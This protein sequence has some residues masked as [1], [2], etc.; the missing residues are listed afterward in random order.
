MILEPLREV[1][2]LKGHVYWAV[3]ILRKCK[4]E[5]MGEDVI[6][7]IE[8]LALLV[9][10]FSNFTL[11]TF[12][13][14]CVKGFGYLLQCYIWFL[15]RISVSL[16]LHRQYGFRSLGAFSYHL[17]IF[18]HHCLSEWH[19]LFPWN[20]WKLHYSLSLALIYL[21]NLILKSIYLQEFYSSPCLSAY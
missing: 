12:C 18:L 10:R 16:W 20:F 7:L 5:D 11:S 17:L 4:F 3:D 1:D 6:L 19:M 13:S 9:A 14:C 2:S 15:W 21:T 8:E